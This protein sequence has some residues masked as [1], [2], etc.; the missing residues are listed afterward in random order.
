MKKLIAALTLTMTLI[1]CQAFAIWTGRLDLSPTVSPLV[2][3]ELH[4]GQWL[5]GITKENLWHLDYNS[6]TGSQ[7]DGQRLHAGVFEAWNAE[8][9]NATFGIV[10]GFDIP[11]A[12]SQAIFSIGNA[13]G[14]TNTFKPAQY[15]ASALSL[16]GL[17]G[18]RPWHDASVNGDLTY[19]VACRLNIAFGVSELQKGL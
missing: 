14:L 19:G 11:V 12:L 1:P 7:W 2:I 13:I 3:R 5:A 18:Y 10:S 17:V 9:G 15:L 4:D 16:D 8:H 6:I